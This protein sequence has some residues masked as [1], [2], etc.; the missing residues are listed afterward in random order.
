MDNLESEIDIDDEFDNA[1]KPM[2]VT[3]V[4]EMDDTTRVDTTRVITT[5]TNEKIVFDPNQTLFFP[6]DRSKDSESKK[7]RL[8]D[9][10]DVMEEK[11]L[12]SSPVQTPEERKA[13]W[14]SQK[15]ELTRFW[16][17]HHREA[18][19]QAKRRGGG[20]KQSRD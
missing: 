1:P 5:T 16:K 15:V 13:W 10:F 6:R 18:V 3:H 9:I 12:L 19:K 20:A 7:P 8:K 4:S 14:Q 2:V 11:G 17:K